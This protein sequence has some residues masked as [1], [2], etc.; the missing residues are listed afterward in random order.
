MKRECNTLLKEVDR[1]DTERM[2]QEE[3]L[4][5][6]MNLVSIIPDVILFSVRKLTTYQVFSSV[7]IY[8]SNVMKKMTET[9]LRDSAGT[10]FL[11]CLS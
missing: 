4:R 11:F 7:N 2:M 3:R 9:A 8:D 6:V 5:N 1:L 10:P